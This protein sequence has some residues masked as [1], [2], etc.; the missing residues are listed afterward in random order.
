MVNSLSQDVAASGGGTETRTASYTLD[1]VGRI[2]VI[3]FKTNGTEKKR[4]RYRYGDL[5]D[6]PSS[7]ETSADAG[8]NWS[9][10]KYAVAPGAG[11]AAEVTSG[12][13][14]FQIANLQGDIVATSGGAGLVDSYSETD[15]YGN[16]LVAPA[17]QR[18]GWL[19]THQRS[20]D[21]VGGLTL[22][23]VRLYNPTTG[24]FLSPDPID[25]G[26]VTSYTYPQDPINVMDTT[27]A[28]SLGSCTYSRRGVGSEPTRRGGMCGPRYGST[29]TLSKDSRRRLLDG[30]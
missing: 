20:S 16:A 9:T 18:Y 22:M 23:G 2:S 12:V 19:G 14:T 25:G 15:E 24:Q 28:T 3:T 4:L 26:N 7:I 10:T 1:P 17:A 27:G 29:R 21:S 30:P 6:S 11:F 13:A 8:A 5:G